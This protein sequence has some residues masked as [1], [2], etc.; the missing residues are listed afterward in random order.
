MRISDWSSDVCSSDLNVMLQGVINDITERK[1]AEFA[2]QQLASRDTLTGLLNRRGIDAGL[3]A[4]FEDRHREPDLAIALMLIDLDYFKQRSEEHT[5]EL[6]SLMRISYAVFCLKKK[7]SNSN[8]YN[9]SQ[10]K[11]KSSEQLQPIAI[12]VYM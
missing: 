9:P 3:A 2:A 6:Q 12:L 4:V 7:K 1:R 11:T 5:S 10:D 8:Y